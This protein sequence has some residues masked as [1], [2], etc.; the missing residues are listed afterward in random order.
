[1][2][3]AQ[4][5]ASCQTTTAD[6]TCHMH[7]STQHSKHKN[8]RMRMFMFMNQNQNPESDSRVNLNLNTHKAQP[9]ATPSTKVQVRVNVPAPC[10]HTRHVLMIHV[11]CLNS[12]H[13]SQSQNN[14]Q[15]HQPPARLPTTPES[16]V[17]ADCGL[18][19]AHGDGA[20]V[21]I[22]TWTSAFR[23]A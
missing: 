20:C 12:K 18:D 7:H 22:C 21:C 11:C 23:P 15:S 6:A 9:R 4:G 8:M 14:N 5:A 10:V 3:R 16:P 19:G 13:T 2:L 17:S 1:M